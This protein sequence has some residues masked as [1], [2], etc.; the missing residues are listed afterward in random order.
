MWY[1]IMCG[2]NYEF[3]KPLVKINGETLVERTIRLL[4]ENGIEDIFISSNNKGYEDFGVPILKH[5]NKYVHET[6]EGSWLDAYYPTNEPTCYLHGDV[7]FSPNAI[8]EI[9]N[10]DVKDDLFICTCEK[11]PNNTCGREPFGYKVVNQVKFRRAINELKS[12]ENEFIVKPFS[13]HLYRMLNGLPLKKNATD[14]TIINNI[15]NV[16]G[17]Y[18]IINDYT[19]DIDRK[20][21]IKELE[22]YLSEKHRNLERCKRL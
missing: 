1:V 4:K 13:W 6:N 19:R 15:F 17:R 12:I 9:I 8:K 10:A 18:L 3:Q 21:Q 2:G 7:F 22:D 5:A 14:F 16:E 20:D 11:A